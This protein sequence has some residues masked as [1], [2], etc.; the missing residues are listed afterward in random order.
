[1][2]YHWPMASTRRAAS[3]LGV[4]IVFASM[5]LGLEKATD[6]IAVLQ[7]DPTGTGTPSNA[8]NNKEKFRPSDFV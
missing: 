3:L 8:T 5:V 7:A 2:G 4:V 6:S 1:M